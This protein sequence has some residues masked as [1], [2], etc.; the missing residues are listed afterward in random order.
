MA[1]LSAVEKMKLEKI[2]AMSGGYVLN[3]GN[4]SFSRFIYDSVKINIDE[5]KY[6][7]YGTSKA[8]CLRTFWELE[9]NI[10]VGKLTEDMLL[11]YKT[12]VTLSDSTSTSIN[13]SLFKDSLDIAYKL[14][15]KKLLRTLQLIQKKLS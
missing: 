6:E 9:G 2:F 11:A 12:E 4:N 10:T 15:G 1:T 5:S 7:K 3:F 13:E 14:Q 8:N